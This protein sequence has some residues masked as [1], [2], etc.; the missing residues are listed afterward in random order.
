MKTILDLNRTQPAFLRTIDKVVNEWIAK[1][2]I[3]HADKETVADVLR[4]GAHGNL[5]KLICIVEPFGKDSMNDQLKRVHWLM[6][7]EYE[8]QLK[9]V[10][11]EKM[12]IE[13]ALIEA[14]KI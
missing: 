11:M 12:G 2:L 10:H 3:Y 1:G 14:G 8:E 4:E 13:P 5:Y 7:C 9:W 6:L